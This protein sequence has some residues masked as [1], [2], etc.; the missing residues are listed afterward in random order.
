MRTSFRLRQ[1]QQ[2][3]PRGSI[4][5]R[6]EL[7]EEP[8]SPL[9][10]KPELG[11]FE[12]ESDMEVDEGNL[13]T[14]SWDVDEAC[15]SHPSNICSWS[16]AAH[17]SGRIGQRREGAVTSYPQREK[18]MVCCVSVAECSHLKTPRRTTGTG[19]HARCA[20]SHNGNNETSGRICKCI[21]KAECRQHPMTKAR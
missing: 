6:L 3:S 9:E 11:L 5:R 12:V 19:Q 1:D 17:Y 21:R 20:K 18:E 7:G 10:L 4:F 15:L 2:A 13:G 8:P 16:A 14:S